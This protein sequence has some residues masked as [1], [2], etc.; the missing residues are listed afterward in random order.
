MWRNNYN[1]F[2]IY[3]LAGVLP[4]EVSICLSAIITFCFCQWH[5]CKDIHRIYRQP[6]GKI[7]CGSYHAIFICVH[8]NDGFFSLFSSFINIACL[9][10]CLSALPNTVLFYRSCQFLICRCDFGGS[11]TTHNHINYYLVSLFMPILFIFINIICDFLNPKDILFIITS[12]YQI[13]QS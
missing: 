3:L 4:A 2:G 9:Q 7:I 13:E 11:I 10:T 5:H 1:L 12:K 6:T 8:L